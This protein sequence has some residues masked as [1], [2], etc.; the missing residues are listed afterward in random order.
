MEILHPAVDKDGNSV[1]FFLRISRNKAA[2][3]YFEKSISP[4]LGFGSIRCAR[5]ILGGA[6]T[7]QMI[8]KGQLKHAGQI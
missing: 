4:M 7:V 5:I 1:D 8:A 3:R 2:Q 6:E